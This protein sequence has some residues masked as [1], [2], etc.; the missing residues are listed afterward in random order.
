MSERYELYSVDSRMPCTSPPTDKWFRKKHTAAPTF[1]RFPS[2]FIKLR[3]FATQLRHWHSLVW[4]LLSGIDLI[5]DIGIKM[6]HTELH[7]RCD[8]PN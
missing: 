5:F 3:I 1:Q 7:G 8:R 2:S 6:A 4:L